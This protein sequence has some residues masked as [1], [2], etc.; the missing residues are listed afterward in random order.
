MIFL[1]LFNIHT[2]RVIVFYFVFAE[3]L[4][5]ESIFDVVYNIVIVYNT[6]NTYR[7]YYCIL[8]VQ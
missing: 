5:W 1:F 6:R 3:L 8:Q 7:Y 2:V 4:Y